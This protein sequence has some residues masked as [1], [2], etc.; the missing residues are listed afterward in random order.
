MPN[1]L[2]LECHLNI[3]QMNTIL[4]FMYWS[5]NTGIRLGL[6]SNN[7]AYFFIGS[8]TNSSRSGE[9]EFLTNSEAGSS[10]SPNLAVM[11]MKKEKY[12]E[13]EK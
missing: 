9:F 3:G 8:Y 4:F 13:K 10:Y 6:Q 12:F 5:K 11:Q 2:V 1:G 7:S